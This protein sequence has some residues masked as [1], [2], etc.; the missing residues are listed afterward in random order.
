LKGSTPIAYNQRPVFNRVGGQAIRE[1]ANQTQDGSRR[2]AFE[3]LL[4]DD[5][6]TKKSK[7]PN[8]STQPARARLWIAVQGW[9]EGTV[10]SKYSNLLKLQVTALPA[11]NGL[12]EDVTRQFWTL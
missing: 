2:Q 4:N 10:W 3:D 8:S 12:L 5:L 9:R 1:V 6:T 7:T 11:P